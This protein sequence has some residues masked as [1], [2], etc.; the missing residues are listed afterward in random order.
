MIIT[1]PMKQA[2]FIFLGA[3]LIGIGCSNDNEA[4]PSTDPKPLP[5]GGTMVV[6]SIGQYPTN[7][8]SK[9]AVACGANATHIVNP[10]A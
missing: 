1:D 4:E 2:V 5:G 6:S 8:S 7:P 10:I 3:G 9:S